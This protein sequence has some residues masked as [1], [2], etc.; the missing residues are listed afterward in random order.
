MDHLSPQSPPHSSPEASP[1]DAARAL[2]AHLA[3]IGRDMEAWLDL[4][5]D[6]A[7][8]EFPYASALG[9]PA[10]LEGKAAIRRYFEGTLESFRDLTLRDVRRYPTTDPDVALAEVHGSAIIL[11][12]GRRYE[13][14]Y[15]MLVA[16]RDG[17][18]VRYREYWNLGPIVEAFGG[19][20]LAQLSAR[21][22]AS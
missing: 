3:L 2:D 6:D 22:E 13:Q 15:V 10:L 19:D 16:T 17:K 11:P 14:D 8:V 1:L 9:A 4:F 5:A 12:A 7:T 18:V 21:A 20:L